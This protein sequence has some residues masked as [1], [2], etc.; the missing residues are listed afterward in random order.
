MDEMEKLKLR[1]ANETLGQEMNK[2]ITESNYESILDEKKMEVAEELGLKEKIENVGWGNM[3]TKE[4]GK[5][6]GQM[7]GQIGGQMVK[8]LITMAEAQMAPVDDTTVQN[9]KE[10]LEGK[11]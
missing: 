5:I 11:R 8:K 1:V 10:H 3:T 7:G 4:V 2:E 6:G 9:A